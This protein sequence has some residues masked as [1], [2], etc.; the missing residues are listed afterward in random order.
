MSLR[1]GCDEW[2]GW[3][4]AAD[5]DHDD[6]V[7]PRYELLGECLGEVRGLDVPEVACGGLIP[8]LALA[9]ARVTGCDFSAAAVAARR[10]KTRAV[11]PRDDVRVVQADA[12]QLP[13]ATDSFDVV[14]SCET[15]SIS[16]RPRCAAGDA[17]RYAQWRPLVFLTTPNVPTS[18]AC[19]T[20]SRRHSNKQDDQGFDRRQWFA[21]VL[22]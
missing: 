20:S 2:H 1:S 18:W 3:R 10:H 6:S 17:L 13:F 15:M 9:G 22:C 14:I 21:Q 11:E 19:T 4:Q 7:C 16:R 8:K 12:Q 5:P